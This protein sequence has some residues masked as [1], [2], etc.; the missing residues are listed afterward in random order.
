MV[1]HQVTIYAAEHLEFLIALIIA[2]IG[3]V[4]AIYYR[5]NPLKGKPV[6]RDRGI[7]L[8]EKDKSIFPDKFNI[9]YGNEEIQRLNKY[10]IILWNNGHDTVDGITSEQNPLRIEFSEDAKILRVRMLVQTDPAMNFAYEIK[11]NKLFLRFNYIEKSEGISLEVLHTGSEKYGDI[12]GSLK[13]FPEG[14][15]DYGKIINRSTFAKISGGN[16][17]ISKQRDHAAKLL[18]GVVNS[19]IFSVVAA[20]FGVIVAF[21]IISTALRPSISTNLS[22]M[23]STL[24]FYLLIM[25]FYSF[26]LVVIGGLGVWNWKRR[27]PKPLEIP[28]I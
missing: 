27:V 2:T 5:K 14:F 7:S 26:L 25:L 6:Y 20:V 24:Y 15:E 19:V 8:I 18:F 11:G 21:S 16:P 28:D 17:Q 4:L 22:L 9:L 1:L 3:I 13:G 12:V 10:Y 23:S